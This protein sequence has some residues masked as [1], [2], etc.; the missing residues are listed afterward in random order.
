MRLLEPWRSR[1]LWLSL[2]LNMF[3]AAL[4]VTLVVWRPHG[5]DRPGQPGFDNLVQRISRNLDPADAAAFRDAMARE[6]P[7]YELGRQKLDDARA[8]V[9]QSVGT[10]PYDPKATVAALAAMQEQMR[11]SGARFDES[12]AMA[13][14]TLSPHGRT[15]LAESLR[16]HRP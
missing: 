16:Q 15:Q 7:W 13:V 9:A 6:R 5:P 1:L 8:A 2:G 3:A 12:L 10:E 14:G 4:L 11:D